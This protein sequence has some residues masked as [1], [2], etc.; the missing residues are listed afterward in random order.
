[1][2][3]C[4]VTCFNRRPAISRILLHTWQRLKAQTV[5]PL[6]LV[7]AVTDQ[8]DI[9]LCEEYGIRFIVHENIPGAKWNAALSLAMETGADAYLIMG[10]DDSIST[11]GY[12]RLILAMQQGYHYAG[13]KNNYFCDLLS[14]KAMQH[15]QPYVANKLI[16]CGRMLSRIAVETAIDKAIISWRKNYL[17][18]QPGD[19][20]EVSRR[21]ADYLQGYNQAKV[22][23]YVKRD[24]WRPELK[25]GL[26]NDSEMRLVMHG[27]VPVCVDSG[28]IHVT[29]FKSVPTA[30]IWPYSILEQKCKP[31]GKDAAMWYMSQQ[32]RDYIYG[33]VSTLNERS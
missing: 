15:T 14:G 4:I 17:T 19:E 9:D 12:Q 32:E 18:Y 30:N 10:D 6:D 7:A 3:V 26:D 33:A 24:L 22:K 8:V 5:Y 13:F 27:I 28:G 2:K 31:C 20:I 23:E 29:D 21:T 11:E 1:M 16:G 25:S